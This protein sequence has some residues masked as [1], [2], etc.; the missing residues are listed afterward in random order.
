MKDVRK[1]VY[2]AL[3]GALSCPVHFLSP[4]AGAQEPAEYVNLL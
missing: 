1:E 3:D 4:P 2:Q